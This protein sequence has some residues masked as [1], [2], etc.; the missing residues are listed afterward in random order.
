MYVCSAFLFVPDSVS[1]EFRAWIVLWRGV[2]DYIPS[3]KIRRG[4]CRKQKKCHVLL[5]SFM[6]QSYSFD[7]D[8]IALSTYFS[9]SFLFNAKVRFLSWTAAK[10]VKRNMENTVF[11]TLEAHKCT[12]SNMIVR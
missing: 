8:S 4:H 7:D 12:T 6:Y 3:V 9:G 10:R 1:S 11:E 5:R 2:P